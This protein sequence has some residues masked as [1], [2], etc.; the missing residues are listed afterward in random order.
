VK[1]QQWEAAAAVGGSSSGVKQQ[2]CEARAD[3]ERQ[4]TLT[5]RVINK[6]ILIGGGVSGHF[7]SPPQ[8]MHRLGVAEVQFPL[9]EVDPFNQPSNAQLHLM[10]VCMAQHL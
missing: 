6:V 9:L 3:E 8:V 4:G 1:Q 5:P 2:Q 10:A 7:D